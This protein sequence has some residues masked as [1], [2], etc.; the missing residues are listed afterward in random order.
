MNTSSSS[1]YTQTERSTI[2]RNTAIAVITTIVVN[3]VIYFVAD[4]AG[5]IPETL[6][7][8]AEQFGI[9]AIILYTALPL[10]AGG[11]LLSFLVMWTTHPVIM[12][13][14]IAAVV[15]IASLFAPLSIAGA[16]T[17]FRA[18]LVAMHV[19]AAVLGT[20]LLLRNVDDEPE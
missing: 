6:P 13:A 16:E 14:L 9:P 4:A 8:N 19:V 20:F 3:L 5:W 18:V 15:F 10:L 12:F 17:S 7:E 2:W 11:V 1:L